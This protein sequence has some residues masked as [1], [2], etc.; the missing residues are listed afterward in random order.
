MS[1]S[2]DGQPNPLI[3][4]RQEATRTPSMLNPVV[5]RTDRFK[6]SP[7]PYLTDLLNNLMTKTNC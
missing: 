1:N 5:T 2:D 3:V 4:Y 7:L 6:K